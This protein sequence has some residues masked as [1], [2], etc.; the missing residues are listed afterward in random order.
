MI[1]IQA[2]KCQK[3]KVPPNKVFPHS[4]AAYCIYWYLS[5]QAQH[6]KLSGRPYLRHL[7]LIRQSYMTSED[8]WSPLLILCEIIQW[9]LRSI[10]IF[11]LS[12]P[13]RSILTQ[14]ASHQDFN[15]GLGSW[16]RNISDFHWKHGP[17]PKK[18]ETLHPAP[19]SWYMTPLSSLLVFERMRGRIFCLF[20]C[21]PCP[22]PIFWPTFSGK[23]AHPYYKFIQKC[24]FSS[25]KKFT[26]R[27]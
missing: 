25:L 3:F 9:N 15:A 6:D 23:I 7:G 10:Q 27:V 13:T 14:S 16:I 19:S 11:G 17:R 21:N 18:S 8:R 12:V 24:S 20:F 5:R 4:Q 22:L 1:P 2:K 26:G